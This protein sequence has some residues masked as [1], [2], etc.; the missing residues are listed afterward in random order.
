MSPTARS[1]RSS[2]FDTDTRKFEV[3]GVAL[4]NIQTPIGVAIDEENGSSSP[5]PN[6]TRSHASV[7]RAISKRLSGPRC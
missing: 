3:R 2:V 7:P 6:C 1:W 5:I 4:A